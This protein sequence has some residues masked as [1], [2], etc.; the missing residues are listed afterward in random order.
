MKIN[1]NSQDYIIVKEN[2]TDKL[3]AVKKINDYRCLRDFVQDKLHCIPISNKG[4]L[5]FDFSLDIK[6]DDLNDNVWIA[7]S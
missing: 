7:G 6:K 3:F 1:F 5:E 4:N 2:K